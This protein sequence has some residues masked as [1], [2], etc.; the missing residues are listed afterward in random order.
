MVVVSSG[1]NFTVKTLQVFLLILSL[2]AVY[3]RY[4]YLPSGEYS[5]KYNL[6][7]TALSAAQDIFPKAY[8][9]REIYSFQGGFEVIGS[10]GAPLGY[11]LPNTVQ[12]RDIEGYGGPLKLFIGLN[13]NLKIKGIAVV[14]HSESPSF[15][16]R[17]Y[18]NS[19]F[20]IWNGLSINEALEK[21]VDSVSGATMSSLAVKK[22]VR[23]TLSRL[24]RNEFVSKGKKTDFYE[25]V[26]IALFLVFSLLSFL[27][28]KFFSGKRFFL[29]LASIVIL[30]FMSETF[31]SLVWIS[32]RARG[33]GGVFSPVFII[34]FL[35][36]SL[37]FFFGRNYYCGYICPYGAL[38]EVCSRLPFKK[39]KLSKDALRFWH[40]ARRIYIFIIFF[41]LLMWSDIDLVYTEPFAAFSFPSAPLAVVLLALIFLGVSLFVPRFWC[42]FLC[43][44]GQIMELFSKKVFKVP[45]NAGKDN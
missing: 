24:S 33:E 28:I 13:G 27:G 21:D 10:E 41:A 29:L 30:G 14:S 15:F 43:P 38:Q 23:K 7:K 1:K 40:T 6:E 36:V 37:S 45:E 4:H 44:T 25:I 20:E 22:S 17:L 16:K 9:L 2:L 18:E 35:A 32:N 8:G 39:K 19:F 11:L 42:N 26:G 31:L 5:G 3:A 34:A 12:D